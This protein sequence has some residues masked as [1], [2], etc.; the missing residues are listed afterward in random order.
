MGTIEREN[1]PKGTDRDQGHPEASSPSI[2]LSVDD[3]LHVL[4]E[5]AGSDELKEWMTAHF[6]GALT[7]FHTR[8]SHW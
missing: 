7:N 4:Q 1:K 5:M 2:T 6:E 3:C 8:I